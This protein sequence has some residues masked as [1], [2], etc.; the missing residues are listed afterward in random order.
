[1]NSQQSILAP[2]KNQSCQIF[3]SD[4]ALHWWDYEG[5]YDTVFAELGWNNTA[6]QEI[7]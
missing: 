3:T 2:V 7:G 6:A 5:G 4:Y 1:V